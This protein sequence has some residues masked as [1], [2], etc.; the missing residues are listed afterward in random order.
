MLDPALPQQNC[1]DLQCWAPL[2]FE[3]VQADAA[4]L[5]NVGVVDFG[6]EAHLQALTDAQAV[7]INLPRLAHCLLGLFATSM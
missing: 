2:V 6:Q 3:N 7:P 5:V 1:A 4:K